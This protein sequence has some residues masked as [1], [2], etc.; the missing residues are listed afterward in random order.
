[1]ISSKINA[2]LFSSKIGKVIESLKIEDNELLFSFVGDEI[3]IK[4]FDNAQRCCEL[5]YMHTDDNLEYYIG[6]K[7]L[8]AGVANGPEEENEWGEAKE[9]QFLKVETSKG[10]FTIVNYNEHNG[11]Y[12]GFAIECVANT[13]EEN[14]THSKMRKKRLP[15]YYS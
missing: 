10:V 15:H 2:E 1:M 13:W 8:G 3:P 4:L 7:L 11:Y 9:S 14:C 6:S 12:G 5:R